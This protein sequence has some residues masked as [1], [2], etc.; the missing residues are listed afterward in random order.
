MLVLR[1][2][3]GKPI[4]RVLNESAMSRKQSW[5]AQLRALTNDGTD[6]LVH[7]YD[8]AMG[9]PVTITLPDGRELEPMVAPPAVQA[10]LSIQLHELLNGKAVS[11]TEVVAA[12]KAMSEVEDVRNMSNEQLEAIYLERST[13]KAA[14][15][16]A[17]SQVEVTP[18]KQPTNSLIARLKGLK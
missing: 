12:E 6:L 10:A 15:P 1:D 4:A 13:P 9:K 16:A 7:A 3:K 5:R 11:Q 8:I 2:D 14:L 17:S 18:T